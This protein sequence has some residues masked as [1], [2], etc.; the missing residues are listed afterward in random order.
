MEKFSFKEPNLDWKTKI[1]FQSNA[2]SKKCMTPLTQDSSKSRILSP[3]QLRMKERSPHELPSQT[4]AKQ[5]KDLACD[6]NP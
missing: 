5:S 4:C 6:L 1:I 2:I 3:L